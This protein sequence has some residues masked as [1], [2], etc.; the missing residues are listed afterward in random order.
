MLLEIYLNYR[1]LD[2]L[3]LV[4]SCVK[5]FLDCEVADVVFK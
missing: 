5:M 2:W 3:T 1:V 4:V